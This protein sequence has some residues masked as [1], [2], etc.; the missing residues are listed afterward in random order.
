MKTASFQLLVNARSSLSECLGRNLIFETD[1]PL[2]LRIWLEYDEPEGPGHHLETLTALGIDNPLDTTPSLLTVVDTAILGEYELKGSVEFLIWWNSKTYE[3]VGAYK[4]K[5]QIQLDLI[6]ESKVESDLL[7]NEITNLDEWLGLLTRWFM[8]NRFPLPVL[9]EGR[10]S[11]TGLRSVNSVDTKGTTLTPGGYTLSVFRK[12]YIEHVRTNM[13]PK[14][15]ENVER[16]MK[17]F[18]NFMGDKALSDLNL[19]DLERYKQE[20][21]GK[22]SDSTIN[23]DVR[24]LK[25]AMQ[26]AMD[27]GKDLEQ[28]VPEVEEY[29]SRTESK[30]SP[31]K[32]RSYQSP[33]SNKGRLV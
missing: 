20:R 28:S 33:G 27:W 29:P 25:A 16:V 13:A 12:D 9:S 32:S 24:T 18:I 19:L 21:K 10:A 26:I 5:Y 6:G 7:Q 23:I 15:V 3:Q 11:A 14:T 31:Y 30:I 22:V 4:E 1:D 2:D 8:I 17:T